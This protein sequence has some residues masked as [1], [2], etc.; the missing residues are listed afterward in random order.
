MADKKE[1]KATYKEAEKF[2]PKCGVRMASHKNRFTCGKC[3]YT[4]WKK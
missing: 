1:K 4:E 3:N 2:C